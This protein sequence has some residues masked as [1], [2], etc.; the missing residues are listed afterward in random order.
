MPWLT[1]K[2]AGCQL[3]IL[4]CHVDEVCADTESACW[5]PTI[6]LLT[7]ARVPPV[8]AASPGRPHHP[9]PG[10]PREQHPPLSRDPV[11]LQLRRALRAGALR[12]RPVR[13]LLQHLCA[14]APPV[15]CQGLPMLCCLLAS[16]VRRQPAPA[17]A[18]DAARHLRVQAIAHAR[19]HS[20]PTAV[21][22]ASDPAKHSYTGAR[23]G[24][25]SF[26][27]VRQS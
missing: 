15:R 20:M 11:R 1:S 18:S 27:H 23:T 26:P 17:S 6:G 22:G 24:D 19:C 7:V 21:F 10:R 12:V 2:V 13:A 8:C 5:C 16:P 9:A 14:R 4:G 25:K 3:V